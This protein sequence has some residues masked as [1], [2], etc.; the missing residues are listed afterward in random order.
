MPKNS[1]GKSKTAVVTGASR[2]IGYAIAAELAM[3]GYSLG[4]TARTKADIEKAAAKLRKKFKG[5]NIIPCDFDAADTGKAEE[6]I[7]SVSR[8]LGNISVL[9][10][11]A[12]SYH[13][14]TSE[15]EIDELKRLLEVNYLAAAGFTKAVLP[16]MK[17]NRGGYIFNIAS[18]CGVQAFPD[19]GGYSA[20]KFALVGYSEA[21]AQEVAG[22]GIKVTALCPSWVNTR[23][24]ERS[25]LN[26]GEMIQPHDI[27]LTVRYLLSLGKSALVREIV[28]HC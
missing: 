28:I 4:I 7:K 12:G 26:P 6:F 9:V 10:N 11:N 22:F 3:Q 2:G 14:G 21:L 24:A 25:S 18:I 13:T 27:A 15:M 19:V 20:S 8:E 16:S 23:N 1:K 17:K 5:V